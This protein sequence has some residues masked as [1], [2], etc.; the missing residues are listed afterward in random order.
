MSL[1]T[2]S[3]STATP[4]QLSY[5]KH[6]ALQTATTFTPPRTRREASDE[7]ERL[8]AL[9]ASRGTYMEA[10]RHHLDPAE[11]PYATEQKPGEVLGYGSSARRR[12]PAPQHWASTPA[13]APRRTDGEPVELGRYETSAGEKRALYG[14]RVDGR[15]RIIDAAAE[16]R[17]RIYTVEEDLCEQGGYGEVMA[18]VADYIAQ[19][20]RLGRIP[21][22]KTERR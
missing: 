3:R 13:P 5:I 12:D 16:D 18:L 17:G 21:M 8:K 15:P 1:L 9:K 6:L 11:L 20:E 22:A 4:R 19:A 2:S 10:P 7:I 14:I